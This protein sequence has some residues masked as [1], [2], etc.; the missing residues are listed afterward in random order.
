MPL[1]ILSNRNKIINDIF[2]IADELNLDTEIIHTSVYILDSYVPFIQNNFNN[3]Y[4]DIIYLCCINISIKF[5]VDNLV[6]DY[7]HLRQYIDIDVDV[8]LFLK[9]EIDILTCIDYKIPIFT[10][11]V[12]F[13]PLLN[14]L[15]LTIYENRLLKYYIFYFTD[16]LL[17][18]SNLYYQRRYIVLVVSIILTSA[19]LVNKK[20]KPSSTNYNNFNL[21]YKNRFA[22][23][24]KNKDINICIS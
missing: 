7:N 8:N 22:L 3:E 12:E 1:G 11:P 14:R 19:I 23:L 21:Y 16:L 24:T 20:R 15:D 6:I 17:F 10:L 9:K 5:C 4:I 18:N 2:K 13:Y